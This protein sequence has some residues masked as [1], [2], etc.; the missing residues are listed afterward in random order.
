MLL[1]A[2]KLS[3]GVPWEAWL[4]PTVLIL[5]QENTDTQDLQSGD[6]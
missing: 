2:G 6:G 5:Q 4:P 1:L 3:L